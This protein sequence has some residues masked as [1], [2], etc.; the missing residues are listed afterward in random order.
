MRQ[1]L[2]TKSRATN[3]AFSFTWNTLP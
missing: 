1:T 2:L 3:P